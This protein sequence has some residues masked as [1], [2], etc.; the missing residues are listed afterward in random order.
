MIVCLATSSPLPAESAPELG[1]RA[2][3]LAPRIRLEPDR[4]L[5]WADA[6]G[7]DGQA[8]A[9]ELLALADESGWAGTS[10]GVAASPVAALVAARTRSPDRCTVVP[11]GRDREFLAPSD[12]GLLDPPPPT[13]LFPLFA[14]VGIRC[15]GDLARLDREAVEVRFGAEGMRLWRLARADDPRPVFGPRPTELPDAELE[16]V[17]YALDRQEQVLFIVHSLL[18]SVS[19]AL[20]ARGQGAHALA[21]EFAL[22]D[23]TVVTHPVRSS[24]PTAERA[25][26]LRIIR[27]ALE[28]VTFSAP[29]TRIALRVE[30][31]AP[32]PGRQGDLFDR[33]FATARATEAALAQLLDRQADA[34]VAA[35]RT[36]HPLPERRIAWRALGPEASAPVA[37]GA[38]AQGGPALSLTLQ[39]AAAPRPV[40]VRL[41][42]RRGG[43]VPT[44]YRDGA[45]VHPLAETLGPD[46]V[47]PVGDDGPAREYFQ[48]V[49]TDGM[50]VLLY[51]D[52]VEDRWF[53]G[54]WWD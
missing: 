12:L 52:L 16:W 6:W 48:G 5:L 9:L 40:A 44:S 33:G 54:G 8:I 53:L 32:V 21:L 25:L 10:A 35:E 30:G 22:A 45:A 1:A 47:T 14:A 43:E 4:A 19:Q 23:R 39:L 50:V 15:A 37:G 27:A 49:R 38:A 18:G 31:V 11:A 7:L 34:L 36:R 17:D 26:W 2:L 41:A 20:A 13:N 28:P 46:R 24:A 42:P 51:R 29:V 3:K